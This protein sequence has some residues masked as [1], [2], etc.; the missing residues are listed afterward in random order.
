MKLL[1]IISVS[2]NATDQL[3]IRFSGFLTYNGLGKPGGTEI[4]WDISA[5]VDGVN[6][7][8]DNINTI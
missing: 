7:L 2:S 5:F 4:K 6:L 8:G 3:Q 1:G